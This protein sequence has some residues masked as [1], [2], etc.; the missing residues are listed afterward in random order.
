MRDYYLIRRTFY[1]STGVATASLSIS[2][3]RC[4]AL[5]YTSILG[6]D[7]FPVSDDGLSIIKVFLTRIGAAL[8]T[9]TAFVVAFDSIGNTRAFAPR[10]AATATAAAATLLLLDP[11]AFWCGRARESCLDRSCLLGHLPR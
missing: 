9:G 4:P 3:L 11:I 1:S 10:L 8:G 7:R 2:T 6:D 5:E